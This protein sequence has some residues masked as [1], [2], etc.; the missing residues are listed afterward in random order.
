MAT[1]YIH[2]RGIEAI[3]KA[4]QFR[5][6]DTF[7]VFQDKM[8]MY[9]GNTKDEL[10]QFL[11]MLSEDACTYTLKVYENIEPDQVKDN[12]GSDGGFNFKLVN[13]EEDYGPH[14]YSNKRNKLLERLERLEAMNELPASE[15]EEEETLEDAAIGLLKKPWE[16]A[17]L[18]NVV[19]GI[20]NLQPGYV[21]PRPAN[22]MGSTGQAMSG[23]QSKE[24][25]IDRLEKAIDT[26]EKY[27]PK[28]IEHLEK[29][30]MIAANNPSQFNFLIS[31]LD[32][33]R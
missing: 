26:L 17:E 27:D 9:K 16:L 29:L 6:V 18:A 11:N 30:A 25:M 21:P 20:F 14:T 12:T 7:A 4:Y 24:T 22:T 31:A 2:F 10:S 28:I 33:M 5:G 8:M 32:N 19:K 3:L 1:K 23:T 13:E 15:M